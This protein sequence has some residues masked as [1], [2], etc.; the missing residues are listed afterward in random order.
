M[1][2]VACR[3]TKAS[4]DREILSHLS[5][6][7]GSYNLHRGIRLLHLLDKGDVQVARGLIETECMESALILLASLDYTADPSVLRREGALVAAARYWSGKTIPHE[8]PELAADLERC[9]ALIRGDNV[10]GAS[11][12]RLYG[13]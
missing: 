12:N 1:P 3:S 8:S 11:T 9:F 5:I 6:S 10:D 2:L 13:K 4:A 7:E